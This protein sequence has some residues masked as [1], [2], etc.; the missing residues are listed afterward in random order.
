MSPRKSNKSKKE[1]E[2]SLEESIISSDI[3]VEDISSDLLPELMQAE[4]ES[5]ITKKKLSKETAHLLTDMLNE[6][7]SCF[8]IIGY[9]YKGGSITIQNSVTQKDADS[10]NT[11]IHKYIFNHA[12]LGKP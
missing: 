7:L 10:I 11:L 4:L 5:Y 8:L 12:N 6:Y 3:D 9:D 1:S 2:E